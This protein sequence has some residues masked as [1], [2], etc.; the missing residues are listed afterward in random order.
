MELQ[1][2]SCIV[3]RFFNLING[4]LLSM[5]LIVDRIYENYNLLPAN[6]TDVFSIETVKQNSSSTLGN[7]ESEKSE[8]SENTLKYWTKIYLMVNSSY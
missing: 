7:N 2:V 4:K 3:I 5:G 1:V 8:K 6:M